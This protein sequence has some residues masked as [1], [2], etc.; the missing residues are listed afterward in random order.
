MAVASSASA[1]PGA[2]TAR[3]VDLEPAMAWKRGHD[4]DDGAEK[5]DEGGSRADRR[6]RAEPCLERFGFTGERHV[7]RAVDPHLQA[8][9]R[10][11]AALKAFL[12]FAH[13]RNEDRAH[14]ARLPVREGPIELLQRLTRPEYLL[15]IIELPADTP[16]IQ[17]LVDDDS[18]GPDRGGDEPQHD[19]LHDQARLHEERPE[20]H[21]ARRGQ[22]NLFHRF[23]SPNPNT[24]QSNSCS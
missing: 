1:I 5:A 7:H 21:V 19:Q 20:G 15:E 22:S 23:Q 2:T 9:R 4:T 3:L 18:P 10:A 12:P 11:R 6:Q 16:V 24:R 14:S 8:D 13:G 17:A